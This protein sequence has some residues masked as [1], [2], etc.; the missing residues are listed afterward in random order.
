MA[1]LICSGEK[2]D[3]I[4]LP[5]QQRRISEKLQANIARVLSHGQYLNGS[6]VREL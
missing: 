1:F 2:M 4:D 5:A 3:F 6:E